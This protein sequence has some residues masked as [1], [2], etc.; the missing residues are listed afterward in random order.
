MG[1]DTDQQRLAE[2]LKGLRVA[3]GMALQALAEASGVSRASLSRIENAEVSPTAETLG[4]LATAYGLPISRLLTP[5]ERPFAPLVRAAEQSVWH[6]AAHGFTREIVSPATGEL[7]V[8][9]LRC[10]IGAGETIAYRAPSVP[11][12]EHHLYLLEGAL[13]VTVEGERH[14]LAVGD[15]LRYRL[16]GAT[17][18]ESGPEGARYILALTKE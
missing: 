3:R 7:T 17:R 5:L 1:I 10:T 13:A 12:Q 6:N 11:G 4:A 9:L 8:E 14:A 18:F 15:C 2:H 16:F